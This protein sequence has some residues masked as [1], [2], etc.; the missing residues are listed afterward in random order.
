[1]FISSGTEGDQW[2]DPKGMF[3]AAAHAT[4]VYTLLGATGLPGDQYPPV[5]TAMVDGDLAWRQHELGHTPG[6]NWPVFLD[7]AARHFADLQRP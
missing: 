3:L 2:V 7:F 6:P 5:G 1:V 4:P